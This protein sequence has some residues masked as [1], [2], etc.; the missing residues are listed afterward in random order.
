MSVPKYTGKN[1]TSPSTCLHTF[2]T[3]ITSL[4]PLNWWPIRL[5]NVVM[6]PSL[7][8]GDISTQCGAHFKLN[9]FLCKWSCKI[10]TAKPVDMRTVSAIS[11]TLTLRSVNT[12]WR[13]CLTISGRRPLVSH[14]NAVLNQNTKPSFFHLKKKFKRLHLL[15]FD[16]DTYSFLV[17]L[18]PL[19][20]AKPIWLHSLSVL[21][22]IPSFETGLEWYL[23]TFLAK[24]RLGVSACPTW[25]LCLSMLSLVRYLECLAEMNLYLL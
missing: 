4:S 13:N 8:H 22:C 15:C 25:I 23:Y 12:T 14:Q 2:W 17:Y 1:F 21:V 11:R 5:Q 3:A 9:F 19:N 7:I 16:M 6:D 24:W 10:E 20:A 18:L